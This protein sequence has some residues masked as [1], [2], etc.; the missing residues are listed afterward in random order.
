MRKRTY[1]WKSEYIEQL[2]TVLYGKDG[3]RLFNEK[4][5]IL[6]NSAKDKGYKKGQFD[7]YYNGKYEP[8]ALAVNVL[9]KQPPRIRFDMQPEYIEKMDEF[10][11]RETELNDEVHNVRGLLRAVVNASNTRADI[12]VLMPKQIQRKAQ[13][14]FW[15]D[16]SHTTIPPEQI[17]ELNDKHEDMLSGFK[18]KILR[19]LLMRHR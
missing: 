12:N 10:S 17:K 19:D 11:K 14:M 1:D 4:I 3:D 2:T 8:I 15:N 5:E 18:N 13:Q 9:E 16:G 6:H 7:I